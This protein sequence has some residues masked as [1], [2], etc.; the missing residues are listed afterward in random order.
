MA[1]PTMQHD[2]HH[3]GLAHHALWRNGLAVLQEARLESIDLVAGIAQAGQF[4]HGIRSE[5]QTRAFW[6]AEHLAHTPCRKS[7]H[8]SGIS[9]Y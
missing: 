7:F 9:A 8:Q 3:T 6:Q 1:S 2:A 5:L 4:D